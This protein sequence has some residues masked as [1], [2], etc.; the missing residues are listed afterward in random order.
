[1]ERLVRLRLGPSRANVDEA[2]RRY[3]LRHWSAY[4][5]RL[6]AMGKEGVDDGSSAFRRVEEEVRLGVAGRVVEVLRTWMRPE[7]SI[8]QAEELFERPGLMKVERK[9]YGGVWFD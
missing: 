5:A 8:A 6:E 7:V 9:E 4:R 1:M 3:A 2:V